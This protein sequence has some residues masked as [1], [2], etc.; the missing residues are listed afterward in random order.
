MK[1][2]MIGLLLCLALTALDVLADE[3]W[4]E[5][6]DASLLEEARKYVANKSVMLWDMKAVDR[7]FELARRWQKLPSPLDDGQ[8]IA[9]VFDRRDPVD[10]AQVV[11]Q[12][13]TYELLGD[14]IPKTNDE[15]KFV[16]HAALR[17]AL[18]IATTH[19]PTDTSRIARLETKIDSPSAPSE[20]PSVSD[21][22]PRPISDNI[23]FISEFER[24]VAAS[25]TLPET[26]IFLQAGHSA[27]VSRLIWSPDDAFIATT[28]Y[29]NSLK[30]WDAASLRLIYTYHGHGSLVNAAAF[31]PDGKWLV[32]AGANPDRSLHVIE[33]RSGRQLRRLTGHGQGV[34]DVVI[35]PDGKRA[36]SVSDLGGEAI[37]WDLQ[38]GA[39]LRKYLFEDVGNLRSVAVLPDGN[40]A[41]IGGYSG[42]IALVSLDEGRVLHRY[43]KQERAV[44]QIV[45]HPGGTSFYTAIGGVLGQGVGGGVLLRWQVDNDKP[46]VRYAGPA[47]NLWGVT[48]SADGQRVAAGGGD[49]T[50]GVFGNGK[51]EHALWVWHSD[52]GELLLRL[53][54]S[55]RWGGKGIRA[56]S[57]SSDGKLLAF[58]SDGDNGILVRAPSAKGEIRRFEG[59]LFA[60]RLLA[61]GE[62][63][64]AWQ[65]VSIN[66]PELA[67][68][69]RELGNLRSPAPETMASR[70][71][72]GV[73][74]LMRWS[75]LSGER[76]ET[77]DLHQRNI[78]LLSTVGEYTFSLSEGFW[79]LGK[80]RSFKSG[81]LLD[82]VATH[83]KKGQV[84]KRTHL[85]H[86]GDGKDRI[87]LH[88]E[89]PVAV[90]QQG[91]YLAVAYK[92]ELVGQD[93]DPDYYIAIFERNEDGFEHLKNLPVAHPVKALAFASGENR[94]LAGVC[95]KRDDN[96][97]FRCDKDKGV[98]LLCADV[99]AGQWVSQSQA[100]TESIDD[101]RVS[102]DGA[103]A[104]TT[105]SN[106]IAWRTSDCG[107]VRELSA[108][109]RRRTARGAWSP[110]QKRIAVASYGRRIHLWDT[111]RVGLERSL[112]GFEGVVR[113]IAFTPDG[114]TLLSLTSDGMIRLWDPDTGALR[115]T[116]IEFDDGEWMTVI[117]EGYFMGSPN[118]DRQLSVRYGDRVYG[119]DQFY[120]LFYRPD[121]VRRKLAGE[122][123]DDLIGLKIKEALHK[124]PPQVTVRTKL[125][126]DGIASV[127]I[128]AS[129]TGGGIGA[130][131]AYHNGKLV[132]SDDEPRSATMAAAPRP[133]AQDAAGVRGM[134]AA[135]A[136]KPAPVPTR[137]QRL[138]K[139][140]VRLAPG[141]NR[142]WVTGFNADGSIQ[143]RPVMVY[144]PAQPAAAPRVFVLA[145]GVDRYRNTR[146]IPTL[147][148]AV[149]DAQTFASEMRERLA[150]V[151]PHQPVEIRLLADDKATVADLQRELERLR[152]EMR[153][154]DVFVWFIASHGMLDGNSAYNVVLHDADLD[155]PGQG[156]LPADR[157]IGWLKRLPALDQMV[158]I[159]TCHAGGLDGTVRGLY[160]ARLGVLARSMG[161]HILASASATEEA[162]DG[163]KENGLFTHS[164][165]RA[166]GDPASD[167]NADRRLSVTEFGRYARTLTQRIAREMRFSQT[168][169]VF[170]YG[171]DLVV[172]EFSAIR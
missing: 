33:R 75:L 101:I 126:K 99:E 22:S 89:E 66:N 162:L 139:V 131:R 154:G 107:F 138:Q 14:L 77:V 97:K 65:S 166:M 106:A 150:K 118:A 111:D 35:L 167:T 34:Q 16:A 120:D 136:R 145:V 4:A 9:E 28:S 61:V 38:T 132:A 25:D 156:V 108:G 160:D 137:R 6:S 115:A 46:P 148:Y 127:M 121:I 52:N 19:L 32:T 64:A 112:I 80:D 105:G 50:L 39:L 23:Y 144:L 155:R 146:D 172:S 73:H 11:L 128:D 63:G 20:G 161:L 141:E 8:M 41:I 54:L 76:E 86:G 30:L 140:D 44:V 151:Y 123:I 125:S 59:R 171:R 69:R 117:P 95:V 114:K 31:T 91:R 27:A 129:D 110:D 122:R 40:R 13:D 153:P 81:M 87:F 104:L 43:E 53:P 78:K 93:L 36:L 98:R 134:L 88:L 5:R 10:A 37:L 159:D 71:G 103:F 24:L 56:L 170:H 119:M 12:A 168:P 2:T 67:K 100:A 82:L 133:A 55:E 163:Y 109:D 85:L 7:L 158:V 21:R 96:F 84:Q 90:S 60:E 74:R 143:S 62:D 51:T 94:L 45:V 83:P 113:Q 142:V 17:R 68:H 29:D 152:T 116:M 165:L 135:S 92:T 79:D 47:G 149:K 164:M 42:H 1:N 147:R 102:P 26:E 57:F 130:L 70:I 18:W 49:T 124:P 15:K 3:R 48:I 157:L 72:D 58:S 169:L